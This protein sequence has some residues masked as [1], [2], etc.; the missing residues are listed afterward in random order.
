MLRSLRQLCRNGGM[1]K[2]VVYHGPDKLSLQD[3]PLP[4]IQQPTDAVVQIKHTT[5]CGTDLHILRGAVP[6]C[7]PGTGL[8]HEGVGIVTAVGS[9]VSKF[10][11][12][13]EVIISCITSCGTCEECV[14]GRQGNCRTGEGGWHLGN[15]IHGCQAQAV[16]IPYADGSLHP[17][18]PGVDP[19]YQVML[20][21]VLPTSLEVGILEPELRPGNTLLVVGVGPIG[22][23][24]VAAAQAYSPSKVIVIDNDENRLRVAE[25]LGATDLLLNTDGKA[26]DRVMQLTD[27]FGVDVAVEAIGLPVGWYLCEDTVKQGG[28]IGILGVHGSPVT[29]HLERMWKRN[30]SLTAGLVHTST[31]PKIGEDIISGA[32]KP[33]H[34]ISHYMKLSELEEAYKMFGNAAEHDTL[35]ICITNDL[36]GWQ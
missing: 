7:V 35:K 4:T 19:R 11:V 10:N 36:D 8:G 13:D 3:R 12:G 29:L 14:A 16:R 18:L 21:D 6:T 24:A 33:E 22:L 17:T 23:A 32:C 2:A 15:S 34:L 26:A 31:I 27:G 9:E 1:M 25:K 20:S 28:K 5:I 30:F